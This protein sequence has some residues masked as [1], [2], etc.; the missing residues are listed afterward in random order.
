MVL[1]G[2]SLRSPYLYCRRS[3]SP[4]PSFFLLSVPAKETGYLLFRTHPPYLLPLRV[5]INKKETTLSFPYWRTRPP[6][7]E[8]KP[9]GKQNGGCTKGETDRHCSF[10]FLKSPTANMSAS[11]QDNGAQLWEQ[12]IRA[13]HLVNLRLCRYA[14]GCP[15]RL[16]YLLPLSSRQLAMQLAA[17]EGPDRRCVW[18]SILGDDSDDAEG[19]DCDKEGEDDHG[20]EKGWS[21]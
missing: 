13:N 3:K 5:D 12:V 18:R 16:F 7:R 4:M 15:E 11:T 14:A 17:D 6:H 20:D 21:G 1:D 9:M 19:D 8:G 10:F 2:T